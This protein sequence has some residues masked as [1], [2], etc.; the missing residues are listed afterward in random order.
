M[1]SAGIL[2]PE[3]SVLKPSD[4]YKVPL[5]IRQMKLPADS[6]GALPEQ[7]LTQVELP[8]VQRQTHR[9]TDRQTDKISKLHTSG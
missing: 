1:K 4:C 6:M 9:Q 3:I 8:P 2:S 7:L 5:N